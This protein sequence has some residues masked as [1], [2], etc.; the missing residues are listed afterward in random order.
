MKRGLGSYE[1]MKYT[2]MPLFSKAGFIFLLS[3]G[4]VQLM[5]R[6]RKVVKGCWHASSLFVPSF[7]SQVS[8]QIFPGEFCLYSENL[9]TFLS[10]NRFMHVML[11]TFSMGFNLGSLRHPQN[12]LH[13]SRLPKYYL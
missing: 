6:C 11:C 1:L 7:L 4:G 8:L 12:I 9:L 5:H 2:S 3:I 13:I 10:L